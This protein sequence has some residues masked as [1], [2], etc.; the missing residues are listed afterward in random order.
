MENVKDNDSSKDKLLKDEIRQR[1]SQVMELKNMDRTTFAQAIGMSQ[2]NLSHLLGGRNDPSLNTIL[3]VHDAFPEIDIDWLI[4]GKGNGPAF[5]AN[6][7]VQDLDIFDQTTKGS[8]TS[9]SREA[10]DTSRPQ[11]S[12]GDE[13]QHIIERHHVEYIE[14]PQRKIVEIRIF[15]DDNTFDVFFPNNQ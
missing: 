2:S 13:R 6:N 9:D 10:A 8:D 4:Y 15:Y 12:I 14:K 1:I 5:S 7:T 3:Q 11:H